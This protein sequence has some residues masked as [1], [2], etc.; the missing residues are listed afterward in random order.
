MTGDAAY[1]GQSQGVKVSTNRSIP[2]KLAQKSRRIHTRSL[3][4]SAPLSTG[5]SS[6][7]T[8]RA[9]LIGHGRLL[10]V[11]SRGAGVRP[12]NHPRRGIGH[13]LTHGGGL[14]SGEPRTHRKGSSRASTSTDIP[15][16]VSVARPS[17]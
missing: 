5:V 14:A 7:P 1:L 2:V 16:A 11:W 6:I 3:T 13:R 15:K 8:R 12:P 4:K 17:G 10:H 9:M